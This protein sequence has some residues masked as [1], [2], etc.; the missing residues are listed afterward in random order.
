[1]CHLMMVTHIIHLLSTSPSRN[2][3]I[4]MNQACATFTTPYLHD[5]FIVLER[6][7][8][9]SSSPPKPQ[10]TLFQKIYLFQRLCKATRIFSHLYMV[11]FTQDCFQ[12]SYFILL[13]IYIYIFLFPLSAN[14]HLGFYFTESMNADRNMTIHTSWVLFSD[15]AA[16]WSLGWL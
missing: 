12:G 14:R 3:V 9:S 1:M 4:F 6:S 5:I 7:C 2:S 13:N 15:R 8:P 10:Q 16:L 11:P